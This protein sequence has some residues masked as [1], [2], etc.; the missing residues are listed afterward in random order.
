MAEIKKQQV[1]FEDKL[2]REAAA[3][4][5]AASK[6]KEKQEEAEEKGGEGAREEGEL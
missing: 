6:A 2:Q 4:S 5:E 3:A 1:A